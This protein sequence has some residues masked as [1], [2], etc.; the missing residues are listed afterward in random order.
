MNYP[1]SFSMLYSFEFSF[2]MLYSF[3]FS[4]EWLDAEPSGL[5]FLPLVNFA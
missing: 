2:S 4:S 1:A 3:E 5:S